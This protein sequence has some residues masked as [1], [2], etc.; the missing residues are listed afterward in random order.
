MVELKQM[1][2]FAEAPVAPGSRR[3]PRT[4]DFSQIM[5]R[6]QESDRREL[7]HHNVRHEGNSDKVEQPASQTAPTADDDA[8]TSKSQSREDGAEQKAM[9]EEAI[10]ANDEQR[11]EDL[12][13][14]P[15][16]YVPI[17]PTPATVGL[18][19]QVVIDADTSVE[20]DVEGEFG[21]GAWGRWLQAI[22]PGDETTDAS[23]D[24]AQ[25]PTLQPAGG[26]QQAVAQTNTLNL[27]SFDE[28]M[29]PSL[30]M[31]EAP[32]QILQRLQ[33]ALT[34]P[35]ATAFSAPVEEAAEIVL[36]QVVRGLAT[37]V[38]DGLSELRIALDPPDLGEIEMRVR[39]MDG[40]VRGQLLVQNPEVK[41]LL[42][43][44]IN[45]LRE[46]LAEQGLE[47]AGLDVDLARDQSSG[48]SE[49]AQDRWG[50]G[51]SRPGG[52]TGSEAA[53]ETVVRAVG[54]PSDGE[55]D[56]VA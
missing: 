11:R 14:L 3:S 29:D 53:G 40:V 22:G 55:V 47:L 36:P 18:L 15:A 10:V 25:T 33:Q 56:Y 41:Q 31:D 16:Q 52:L 54:P 24:S 39:T 45:R 19:T 49:Q 28:L 37:L 35:E 32:S 43:M 48:D 8:T 23:G 30:V 44:Q 46:S 7:E 12:T 2:I 1:N 13:Q 17:A 38:R 50:D 27:L 20:V 42:E 26:G 51:F 4:S 34:G 21:E 9:E 6:A 5:D